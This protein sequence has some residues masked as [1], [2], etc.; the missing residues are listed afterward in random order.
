MSR[1]LNISLKITG[2]VVGLVLLLFAG[3]AI[4][5]NAN[6]KI[7]LDN[8]TAE[9]NKNIAGT[10]TIGSMEPTMFR[11]FPGVSVR[12][13]DVVLSD[14]LWKTHGHHLLQAK[15]IGISVDVIAAIK[16]DTKINKMDISDATIY[17]FT[18]SNGYS[19]T[20]I[21]KQKTKDTA[22]TTQKN[23]STEINRFNLKKVNFVLDNVKRSKLFQFSVNE[24]RGR[25]NYPG[26]GWHANIKLNTLVRN[27]AFNTKKGS[28]LK[29]KTVD[30]N[31]NVSYN[32]KNETITLLKQKLK[33]DKDEIEIGAKFFFKPN[34]ANFELLINAQKMPFNS[35]VSLLSPAISKKLKYVNFKNPFDVKAAIKGNFGTGMPYVYVDW[36]VVNNDFNTPGGLIEKGSF[37]GF[38]TNE[39]TKGKG[40]NDENSLI[41]ITNFKGN[42]HNIPLQADTVKVTNLR[43]PVIAG[44]FN[45]KFALSNLNDATNTETLRFEKGTGS[46]NL[47]YKADILNYQFVKPEVSGDV[48][49]KNAD[50]FYFPRKLKLVNSALTLNFKGDDL[51]LKNGRFQ[52]GKSIL[53][54][55]G[56]VRNFMNFYYTD[57]QKIL[58]DWKITS[59]QLHL[60]EFITLLGTKKITKK[61]VRSAARSNRIVAQINDIL[62]ASRTRMQM[63]VNKVIYKNFT[64][65]NMNATITLSDAGIN[66]QRVGMG[67]ANG[68]VNLSGKIIP[69][70]KVNRFTL[71]SVV[72]NV[73]VKEFFRAFDNFGQT[74]ITSENLSGY[75]FAKTNVSG[76]ITD[77]GKLIPQSIFGKTIFNLKKGALTNFK[78]IQEAG[79]FAFPNRNLSDIRISNLNGVFD[80]KGDKIIINPMMINSSVINFNVAGT[81]GLTSGTNI[82]LDIPLRNPERDAEITDK[83]LKKERRMKGIVLHLQAVEDAEGKI[84]IKWNK[85]GD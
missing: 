57:P 67:H 15:Q 66:L 22:D 21:F 1:W 81:Y 9:L 69:Q 27:L 39:N 65:R 33:I 70:K 2:F 76:T 53:Y 40:Y 61:K 42:W 71:N 36:N 62:A 73:N 25:I 48:I 19:N 23:G 11:G 4:Y 63:N 20:S 60:D 58:L 44:R 7:V 79:Q 50:I 30:G 52:T 68:K 78:P 18:D 37:T 46:L 55:N 56:S 84:K 32:K 59:P 28:F 75:F 16:G 41:Q 45:S 14:S 43:K 64:G 51:F 29:N 82:S 26:S 77:N 72:D 80:I 85:G 34:P 47:I 35:A 12:L 24:L 8:I 49:I 5:I 13:N 38:Y 74:A 6:K 54:M 83:V 10:L 31:L 3:F 17:L